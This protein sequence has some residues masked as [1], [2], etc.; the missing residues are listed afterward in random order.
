M[1][2]FINLTAKEATPEQKSAGVI[3]V[4]PALRHQFNR[5][6][7]FFSQP[8]KA[9]IEERAAYL[10][11]MAAQLNADYVLVDAPLFLISTLESKLKARG[12]QPVYSLYPYSGFVEV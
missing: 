8:S 4:D 5:A 9:L 12:I 3:D 1:K 11:T 7:T 2:I 10:T 6:L